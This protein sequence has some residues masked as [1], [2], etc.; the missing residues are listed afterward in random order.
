MKRVLVMMVAILG[1]SL[2]ACGGEAL[3]VQVDEGPADVE[4][5]QTSQELVTCTT[6][7]ANGTFI[8]CTG[9]TC[10]TFEGRSVTCDG[11]RKDCP[12]AVCPGDY[13]SCSAMDGQSCRSGT[14]P[15]CRGDVEGYCYCIA[16]RYDC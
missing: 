5:A 2:L 8:S 6:A 16:G 11:V 13:R 4:L 12:P 3:E 7:C 10:S 9:S 1:V 14:Q 15:C